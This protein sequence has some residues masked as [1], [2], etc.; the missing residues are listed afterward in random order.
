MTE[1]DSGEAP[2]HVT[3]KRPS[4]LTAMSSPKVVMG[5]GLVPFARRG[6]GWAVFNDHFRDALKGNIFNARATGFVQSGANLNAVKMGVRGAI[7]P[8]SEV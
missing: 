4:R 1:I 7:R 8:G 6:R 3:R 2:E 5:I